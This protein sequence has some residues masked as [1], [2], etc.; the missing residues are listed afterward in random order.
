MV[1][2]TMLPTL[3]T[4]LSSSS[5]LRQFPALRKSW[6]TVSVF[7]QAPGC[8]LMPRKNSVLSCSVSTAPSQSKSVVYPISKTQHFSYS[9]GSF[10]VNVS[11]D[12]K[13]LVLREVNREPANFH[14][15]WLRHNCQCVEC[16]QPFSGQKTIDIS[17]LRPSFSI[18]SVHLDSNDEARV[19][20]NEEDHCSVY[21]LAFLKQNQ[22]STSEISCH[23][24]SAEPVT[25]KHL[26]KMEYKEVLEDEGLLKWMHLID[27]YGLCMVKNVPVSEEM[28]RAMAE[29]MWPVQQ[30]IYGHTWDVKS[31][32][33]PINVAY[34]DVQLDFHMDLAYYESPPGIQFLHCV[35]FDDC[36]EGGKS[37]F[38]DA[39]HVAKALQSQHHNDFEILTRVPATFQKVHTDRDHPVYMKYQRPHISVDPNG[40]IVGVFWSPAF[41]GP[42]QVPESL[43][44]PYYKAYNRFASLVHNSP[45]RIEFRLVPGDL[46]SFNNRRMLHGRGEIRLNGGMRHLKGCY[47]NIDEF[48]SRLEVL[49]RKSGANLR[50]RHVLNQCWF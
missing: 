44:E 46:I 26:P 3:M 22:Y 29:R 17:R 10:S 1:E 4:R 7:F 31:D 11:P 48:K 33:Q 34:S 41:E 19:E 5:T 13:Y 8:S 36:V 40:Q 23:R 38:V 25:C 42:L 2:T 20:W 28:V 21:P 24:S 37:L 27:E 45:T 12:K 14:T 49:S 9:S 32:L 43:V 6:K 15:V 39:W 50:I 47:M 30:T 16:K 18:S 35:K